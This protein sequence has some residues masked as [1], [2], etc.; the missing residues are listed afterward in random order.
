MNKL[1]VRCSVCG[2]SFKTPSAKKT[3]CPTCD[4]EAKRARHHQASAQE[5]RPIAAPSTVDVRAVLRAGQ[6]N[7]G[8]FGAYKAPPPPPAPTP[9][10]AAHTAHKHGP[11]RPAPRTGQHPHPER[12]VK[13]A[14][15]P[16]KQPRAPKPRIVRKPFEASPEQITAIQARYLELAQPE[17]DGIRH[18]IATELGI[19][20]RAVK[21]AVKD[22]RTERSIASWWDTSQQEPN[23][24]QIE[25]VRALYLPLLPEP[26][27]GV[28]KQIAKE[29]QLANTSVYLAI[30]HI[31]RDLALPQY[32]ARPEI[33][34]EPVSEHEGESGQL[35]VPPT[36]GG[37]QG[38]T[39]RV[40]AGE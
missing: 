7:Q 5:Q 15:R 24:E 32:N 8:E 22:V 16:P 28:H 35:P 4:A 6:E 17:F 13:A 40:H 27:I 19:P 18:Q 1:K 30:G 23:P 31:R 33:P 25:Q 9:A 20:L 10:E 29:L 36:P 38:Q 37:A 3:V 34:V 11:E 14:P 12:G 26:E 21:L 2:K 39:A